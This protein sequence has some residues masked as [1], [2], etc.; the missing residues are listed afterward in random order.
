MALYNYVPTFYSDN[1]VP[2]FTRWQHH[3]FPFTLVIHTSSMLFLQTFWSNEL[4]HN[5]YVNNIINFEYVYYIY[6]YIEIAFKN[7]QK[8][9]NVYICFQLVQSKKWYCKTIMKVKNKLQFH[10]EKI[11]A[12]SID[13]LVFLI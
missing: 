1:T 3:W 13:C 8:Q 10:C 11:S 2:F 12:A 7:V 5:I 6:F 4:L 9:N